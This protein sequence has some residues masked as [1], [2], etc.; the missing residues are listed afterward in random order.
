MLPKEI[1]VSDDATA[2]QAQLILDAMRQV[3]AEDEKDL[4]DVTVTDS[5]SYVYVGQC[6]VYMCTAV[7]ARSSGA[8]GGLHECLNCYRILYF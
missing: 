1:A 7:C 8:D 6:I 3:S 4:E 5:Y 2:E